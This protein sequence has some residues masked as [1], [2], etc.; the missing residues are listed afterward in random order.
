MIIRSLDSYSSMKQRQEAH[1]METSIR[2]FA[3]KK[4]AA[5]PVEDPSLTTA[6]RWFLAAILISSLLWLGIVSVL[7]YLWG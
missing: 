3:P 6:G 1:L 5:A 7:C 2:A 4:P